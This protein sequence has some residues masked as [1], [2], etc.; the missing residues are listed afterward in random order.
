MIEGFDKEENAVA[1]DNNLMKIA[2]NIVEKLKKV[3]DYYVVSEVEYNI[4]KATGQLDRNK[5]YAVI[6]GGTIPA[7]VWLGA[8]VRVRN[9]GLVLKNDFKIWKG[10]LN[11][12]IILW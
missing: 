9:S 1:A 8:L 7:E 4:L 5:I 6:P 11:V 12:K 2:K 10:K 3:N